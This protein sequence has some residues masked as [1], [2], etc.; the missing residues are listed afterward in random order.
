[1]KTNKLFYFLSAVLILGGLAFSGFVSANDDRSGEDNGKSEHAK[2]VRNYGSSLEVHFFDNGKVLVRGAKVTA[3]SGDNVK[4][5]TS[6]GSVNLD[7]NVNVMSNT[8][9][10]RKYGG[11][12]SISE[13]SVGDFISFQ[14]T[15]VTT[16]SS[17]IRVNANVIKNWTPKPVPVRTTI[18]GKI[19]SI[20]GTTLPTT[21]V[22][23]TEDKVYTVNIATNTSVLNES[24]LRAVLSSFNV[25]DKIRVYGTVHSDLTMDATV[26]RD[27]SL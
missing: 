18:E 7:W 15:L 16:S 27:T 13:I 6:W 10:I 11:I 5:F 23:K 1:M 22:V 26:V 3:V 24:W 14:G 2:E 20:E 25:G 19:S 21:M 4:A 17:P 8:Q 12:G 9:T